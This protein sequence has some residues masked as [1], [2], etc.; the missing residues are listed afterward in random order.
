MEKLQ[1]E[2]FIEEDRGLWGYLK[3]KSTMLLSHG[4]DLTEL[5]HKLKN[6]LIECEGVPPTVSV[7]FKHRY[8]ALP[9]PEY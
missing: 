4:N 3:Y 9:Y 6:M 1:L 2:V 8:G 7:V 5:E